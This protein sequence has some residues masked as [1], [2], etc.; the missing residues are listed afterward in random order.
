MR[1]CASSDAD[2]ARRQRLQRRGLTTSSPA[3]P[4]LAENMRTPML[5]A[6]PTSSTS[7]S[8]HFQNRHSPH[9]RAPTTS[10]ETLH[11]SW[12]RLSYSVGRQQVLPAS[13][14]AVSAGLWIMIGPSGAGK[15]SLLGVLA[16][17]K[18][19]GTVGGCVRLNGSKAAPKARREL[20]GYVT[21]DDVLPGASTV[22]EHLHFHARLRLPWLPLSERA[23]LVRSTLEKLQ[24]TGRAD[25]IIGDAFLRGLSGGERRRVSVATEL[26]VLSAGGCGLVLMDEPLSGLDSANATLLLAALQQLTQAA[27]PRTRPPTPGAINA[28]GAADASGQ[29]TAAA[30]ADAA[31]RSGAG[32]S[33]AED[34]GEA[35]EEGTRA[36]SGGA[37]AD[38]DANANADADAADAG[39]GAA[40][41]AGGG[42]SPLA[43]LEAQAACRRSPLD[44]SPFGSSPQSP[45]E[46]PS[47]IR[48]PPPA[49]AGPTILMTVHQ[50][51]H[52]LLESIAGIVVMG[53]RGTLLYCGSR[54]DA[55]GRCALSDHFD[56]DGLRLASISGNPAESLLEAMG[57]PDPRTQRRLERISQQQA[58][59]VSLGLE[60]HER[61]ST[62]G[63]AEGRG[64]DAEPTHARSSP[65][66]AHGVGWAAEVNGGGEGGGR[67]DVLGSWRT[68]LLP[69]HMGGNGAA[70]V[71]RRNTQRAG[72]VAQMSVL[73]ARQARHVVRHPLLLWVQLGTTA[74][75][76]VLCGFVFWRLNFDLDTGVITRV[77]LIFFLGLYFM[78]TALAPL[79]FW[80][81][82]RLLY[83]QE[84][85]AGCYGPLSYVLSRT[86]YDGLMQRILPALLCAAIVYPMA[87]LSATGRTG[88]WHAALFIAALCLTNMLGTAVV[89]CFAI[90]CP[91][92]SVATVL[93]VCFVLLSTLFCG[94][95]VNLPTLLSRGGGSWWGGLG[96][97]YLSYLYYLNELTM[98]DELMGQTVTIKANL[99]PGQPPDIYQ[100]AGEEILAHLGYTLNCSRVGGLGDPGTPYGP[101]NAC[102]YDL[103]VPLGVIIVAV[104]SSVLLLAFCVKDT[105]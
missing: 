34:P 83:F 100:V 71:W 40:A 86:L 87:G 52:R 54:R 84:R 36:S 57:D 48:V 76:S 12:D 64:W 66:S 8:H 27:N 56:G 25:A 38:A 7:A 72:F 14:G 77:G 17:R 2:A 21:Q 24:L 50:P 91:S 81:Q 51:S 15:S 4:A 95:V 41:P 31:R 28:A 68:T 62:G 26:L 98:S 42:V 73:C 1:L 102:W 32:P 16:G 89:T 80:S 103:T 55:D 105:H 58:E 93:S 23:A 44:S 60:Q 65:T 11:L 20:L 92:A 10:R 99:V 3:S 45:T 79:P 18:A 101:G 13:S 97:Q 82:E 53:P 88:P 59:R 49:P 78:L 94:F 33:E 39:S 47:T 74:G 70:T 104:T 9:G 69:A 37:D 5:H 29:G 22:A 90:I 63:L 67:G 61:P 30:A 96:P 6:D 35:G 19:R 75:V 43:S 85:A 46:W